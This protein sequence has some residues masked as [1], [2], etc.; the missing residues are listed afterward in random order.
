M[1]TFHQWYRELQVTRTIKALQKNNFNARFVPTASQALEEI[2]KMIPEGSTVGIGG[3]V[4]LTQIGFYEAAQ[5]RPVKFLNPFAQG[6]SAE[7][8]EKIRREILF[9]DYFLCSSNA[10]TEDGKLYNIDATGNRVGAM[11]FGP[12]NVILICGINKIVK[13]IPEAQKK[14]QEWVSPMN[15]KRLGLKN[16]CAETGECSDCASPSRICNIYITLAKKPRRMNFTIFL[17]GEPLGL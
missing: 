4:T 2:W 5:K 17:V 15:V 11:M 13:D 8:T 6:L 9:A 3:S 12:R 7:E 10:V 14:V 1:T 16:P